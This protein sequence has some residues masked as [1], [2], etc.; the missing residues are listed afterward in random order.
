MEDNEKW[1]YVV[2]NL[3]LEIFKRKDKNS[4]MESLKINWIYIIMIF[5]PQNPKYDIVQILNRVKRS[6]EF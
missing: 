2:F 4:V 5:I 3:I 1:N 6:L